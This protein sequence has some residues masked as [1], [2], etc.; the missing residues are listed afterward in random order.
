M[1]KEMR[2]NKYTTKNVMQILFL[3]KLFSTEYVITYR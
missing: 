3:M 2:Y 1:S